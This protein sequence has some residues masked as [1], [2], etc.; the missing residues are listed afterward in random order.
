MIKRSLAL[1]YSKALFELDRSKDLLEKR[2]GYFSALTQLF[3]HHPEA[4]KYL[5]SPQVKL[6]KKKVWL[7]EHLKEEL[8]PLFFKFL[9]YLIEKRRIKAIKQ[10]ADEYRLIV[11]DFLGIWDARVI[12][13][14]PLE[15]EIEDKL[16][17]RLENFY[18]HKIK[19][20][21]EVN[22]SLIG[23]AILI[24]GNEMIDWSLSSRLKKMKEKLLTTNV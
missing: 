15:A 4:L 14:I 6:E 7:Q 20:T 12:S 24:V 3:D 1:R 16:K 13:A 9:L 5:Y 23:G 18:H 21:K 11:N 8:D 19:I 22:P 17:L 10:I 2:L